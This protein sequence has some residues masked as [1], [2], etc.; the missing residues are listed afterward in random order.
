M[1]EG[2]VL[3]RIKELLHRIGERKAKYFAVI[4]LTSGYHQTARDEDFQKYTAFVISA[5]SPNDD[6]YRCGLKV[7]R[8]TSNA[9][10]HRLSWQV[11]SITV[12][13]YILTIASSN[14]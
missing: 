5:G 9:R 1:M 4:D 14:L 6:E 2:C 12:W 10:W 8:S 3:P 11:S 7:H 13:S